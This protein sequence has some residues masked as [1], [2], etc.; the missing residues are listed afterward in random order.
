MNH[1]A[2]LRLLLL[3]AFGVCA[4]NQAI[5]CTDRLDPLASPNRD[6]V[7]RFTDGRS[8]P[9]TVSE[10]R[11]LP[12]GRV[13]PPRVSPPV[14]EIQA[15]KFD[16]WGGDVVFMEN[17]GH[18]GRRVCRVESWKSRMFDAV[19]R[20]S[21]GGG[22]V[23]R[24]DSSGEIRTVTYTSTPGQERNAILAKV[25]P[26]YYLD[27]AMAY[28]YDDR[29]HLIEVGRYASPEMRLTSKGNSA[30][31]VTRRVLY[32]FTYRD[33]KLELAAE[34]AKSGPG[35]P[36]GFA[37][38]Q[39][40]R[41]G[42]SY[43]SYRYNADGTL[44][45]QLR[46][47]RV[48]AQDG[49]G[50]PLQ[51]RTANQAGSGT[52]WLRGLGKGER[53]SVAF[54]FSAAN[55]L[56]HLQTTDPNVFKGDAQALYAD[57]AQ[58]DGVVT[59]Y[60][61]PVHPVPLSLVG[62]DFAGLDR[63]PRIRSY[64]HRDGSQIS[65]L[66]DA[67]ARTPRQRQWRGVDL[68]RQEMYGA[69]GKLTRVI[70]FDRQG[71]EGDGRDTLKA[72]VEPGVLKVTPATIGP[73]SYRVYDYNAQGKESLVFVCWEYDVRDGRPSEHFPWWTPD[74]Q[75]RYDRHVR[76]FGKGHYAH[77]CGT[78]DGTML[79]KGYYRIKKYMAVTYGYDVE[80]LSYDEG[81]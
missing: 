67:G 34:F 7:L 56:T 52:K 38:D 46:H 36:A 80:K 24:V 51:F 11:L 4:S 59:R 14:G 31:D 66:F 73:S 19:V 27:S 22:P 45:A 62:N 50:P 39:L 15:G 13:S 70:Q 17:D 74:P 76:R 3:S 68:S 23:P 2:Q 72:Y 32:C 43:D 60:S 53:A 5:A 28:Y 44:S 16:H 69:D 58:D 65:E 10:A 75:P 48:N 1:R 49:N 30:Q 26:Y 20:D 21:R 55:T 41:A 33:D 40:R 63:Y 77:E 8:S 9:I 71:G 18:G 25:L 12:D 54:R 37:C 42:V 29:G 47:Y 35:T 81:R 6:V 57:R 64:R 78:P 61:F 79:V